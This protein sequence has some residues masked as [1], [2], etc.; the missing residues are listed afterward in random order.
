MSR[1][2][3]IKKDEVDRNTNIEGDEIGGNIKIE[4][5]SSQIHRQ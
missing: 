2:P 3:K 5:L 1:N 4:G